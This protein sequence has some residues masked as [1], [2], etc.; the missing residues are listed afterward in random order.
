MS[1]RTYPDYLK[2]KKFDLQS[3]MQRLAF[4]EGKRRILNEDF[5]VGLLVHRFMPTLVNEVSVM[6]P[7]GMRQDNPF[8]LMAHAWMPAGIEWPTFLIICSPADALSIFDITVEGS[9]SYVPANLF[10]EPLIKARDKGKPELPDEE[11]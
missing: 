3:V 6:Q 7:A 10:F 8:L 4:S 5:T 11:E 9:P 1:Y 2:D